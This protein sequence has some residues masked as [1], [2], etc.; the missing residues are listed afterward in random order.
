MA[1]NWQDNDLASFAIMGLL[2]LFFVLSLRAHAGIIAAI[3]ALLDKQATSFKHGWAASRL[4]YSRLFY[5]DF[6]LFLLLT[7]LVILLSPP[8]AFLAHQ[9]HLVQAWTLGVFGSL[10]F[11]AALVP[12]ALISVFAP[13][14]VVIFDLKVQEAFDRSFTL[15]KE[16]LWQL[17]GFGLVFLILWALP[18]VILD[19]LTY[20]IH[21][22]I[23]RLAALV[24][25]SLVEIIL[26][27]F[28][29]TAWV[30]VFLELIKPQKFEEE[31]VVPVP[32]V[33]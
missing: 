4:F 1:G 30:L 19:F 11:L 31:T 12:A 2:I 6:F 27:T 23:I 17:L 18:V 20:Y 8:V 28:A 14:F 33:I 3:K 16:F 29:Q 32:E 21:G 7:I 24:V 26:L 10:I 5:I 13:M 25:I 22:L 9:H 15:I